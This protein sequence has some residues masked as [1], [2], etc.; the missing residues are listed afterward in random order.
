MFGENLDLF[1]SFPQTLQSSRTL[2]DALDGSER[3]ASWR[4]NNY[5][6]Y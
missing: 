2:F 4:N 3:L 1:T 5:D 6:D